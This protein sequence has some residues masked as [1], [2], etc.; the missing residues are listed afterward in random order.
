MLFLHFNAL[1]LLHALDVL[2][3]L[4]LVTYDFCVPCVPF[5]FARFAR[6]RAFRALRAMIF[7]GWARFV[8]FT[9]PFGLLNLYAAF[10]QNL[11]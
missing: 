7:A 3:C 6:Y 10:F 1:H 4:G 2:V 5:C 9:L 8:F 11:A